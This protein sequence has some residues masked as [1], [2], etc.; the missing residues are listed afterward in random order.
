MFYIIKFI[1]L[2]FLG[3]S[4]LSK[5]IDY[6]TSIAE[7]DMILLKLRRN[8]RCGC[9]F[10]C[11]RSCCWR[12]RERRQ[13]H[14]SGR[15]IFRLFSFGLCNCQRWPTLQPVDEVFS[16]GRLEGSRIY[17]RINEC[18]LVDFRPVQICLRAAS[19]VLHTVVGIE[20]RD[21]GIRWIV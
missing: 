15:Q 10:C 2:F 8:T 5:N 3:L 19:V 7:S 11:E 21:E 12:L 4:F 13:F 17:T 14:Q 16:R 1:N 9:D 6:G 18:D 20:E